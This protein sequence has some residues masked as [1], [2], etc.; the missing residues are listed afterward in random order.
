M[1]AQID[2]RH[3]H[4][5]REKE[6]RP[7]DSTPAAEKHGGGRRHR[8]GHV[9]GGE[10]LVALGVTAQHDPVFFIYAALPGIGSR[11]RYKRLDREVGDQR[12]DGDG[13]QHGGAVTPC[14]TKHHQ[15]ERQQN[16]KDAALAHVGD[17]REKRREKAGRK[18]IKP[19][20]G[21]GRP[22]VKPCEGG[23]EPKRGCCHFHKRTSVNHILSFA[24]RTRWVPP[25]GNG[26]AGTADARRVP[27]DKYRSYYSFPSASLQGR[28]Q[29]I[30]QL[31]RKP[32]VHLL[33]IRVWAD[34][35]G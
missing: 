5:E 26:R 32:A 19:V 8:G 14:G 4:E 35:R 15:R 10:A 6:S 22:L 20:Y 1:H 7:A 25:R 23:V 2:P 34:R 11:P 30:R 13:Q 21:D 12:S 33:R 16:E 3:A 31:C 28:K 18:L 29:F 24:Q 17:Q 9:S 27:P